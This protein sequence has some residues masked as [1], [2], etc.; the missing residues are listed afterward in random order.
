[1]QRQKKKK[2]QITN[3]QKF[4]RRKKWNK[5]VGIASL[6]LT[7]DAGS[8]FSQGM[9]MSIKGNELPTR[10]LYISSMVFFFSRI[11]MDKLQMRLYRL[12]LFNP[13]IE[14]LGARSQTDA[15]GQPYA[16]LVRLNP[17]I[18]NLQ[19]TQRT[20]GPVRNRP[21]KIYTNKNTHNIGRL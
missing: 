11:I 9:S 15:L 1:M 12:Y 5:L 16:S 19:H 3:Q 20:Q 18:Y 2:K 17:E 7:T 10:K 13:S 14:R 4:E 21:E 6:R 8:D